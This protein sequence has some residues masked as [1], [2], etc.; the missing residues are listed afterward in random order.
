MTKRKI[1]KMAHFSDTHLGYSSGRRYNKIGI[2]QRV[3]DG[4]KA[5]N[6]A[7]DQMISEKVDIAILSGDLFH[8]AHPDVLTIMTAQEGLRR[9][10]KEGIKVYVGAGNHDA[11]DIRSEVPANGVVNEPSAGIESYVD[12]YIVKDL[13]DNIVGHF[14]SHHAYTDQGETMR[15][16][17][18]VDGKINIL[19]SHGSCFDTN[20]NVMLHSPQEPREV[21]IPEFIMNL[22]WDYTFLGHIHERGWIGSKDGKTDTAK[23][24]QFYGG[25]LIR[26]GF[27]DRPCKL[28]RGWTLWTFYDDKTITPT[29][30]NVAQRPQIDCAKIEAKD[31]SPV[32]I[33]EK[34]VAQ[35]KQIYDTYS[36]DEGFIPDEVAPIVRQTVVG[37]SPVAYVAIDWSNSS[38]YTKHF[39]THTLKKVDAKSDISNQSA[40]DDSVSAS[41]DLKTSQDIVEAFDTWM[42]E[43]HSSEKEIEDKDEVTEKAKVLLKKGQ[44]EVLENES[45]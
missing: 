28:E 42:A 24:K 4:Y 11:T 17:K 45:K 35:L 3:L 7:I 29:F 37:I 41:D 31:L 6:E 39:L 15:Q 30:F 19:I 13:T 12:P 2:N 8:T 25:S 22:P 36:N 38:K 26:R 43:S 27:S 18:L 20:M 23:R 10:A 1:L 21:V 32:E 16:I 40:N 5:Y 44:N 9:L 33:E 14:L 34:L